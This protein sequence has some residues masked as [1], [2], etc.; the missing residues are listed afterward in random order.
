MENEVRRLNSLVEQHEQQ[1]TALTGDHSRRLQ[2]ECVR[3]DTKY[4]I[5]NFKSSGYLNL[6][7]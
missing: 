1:M 2:E 6:F 7:L 4:I 3:L 5:F